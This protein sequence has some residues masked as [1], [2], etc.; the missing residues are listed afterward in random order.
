MVTL[1]R[2]EFEERFIDFRSQAKNFE[3]FSD[4][5]NVDISDMADKFQI[6][7]IEV[8]NNTDLKKAFLANTLIQFYKLY[9]S[10][11]TYPNLSCH[12]KRCMS[13][14]GSTYSCEQPFSR[15]RNIKSS[16]RSILTDNHLTSTLRIAKNQCQILH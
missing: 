14:F 2:E 16:N 15:M 5:I 9:I 7:L 12:A 13:L 8:Q 6:E 1:L 10:R 4:P 3:I 11:E